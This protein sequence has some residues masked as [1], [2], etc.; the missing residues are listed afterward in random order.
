MLW[1]FFNTP[2]DALGPAEEAAVSRLAAAS[3]QAAGLDIKSA[4][5]VDSCAAYLVAVEATSVSLQIQPTPR[6]YR[7]NF[8]LNYR[9]L[10]P[11][12]NRSYRADVLEASLEHYN[13]IWVNGEKF[14][15]SVEATRRAEEL[16]CAWIDLGTVLERWS[17]SSSRPRSGGSR[18][19]SPRSGRPTRAELTNDILRSN[20]RAAME[21]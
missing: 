16:Q 17:R 14:E 8:P 12:E 13:V 3:R 11:G 10:F 4:A 6:G 9:S 2:S 20:L 15:F 1:R 19:P 18:E 21:Q 7:A 5:G